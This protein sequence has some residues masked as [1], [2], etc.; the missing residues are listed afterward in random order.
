MGDL[1][2]VIV[3]VGIISRL[4]GGNGGGLLGDRKMWMRLLGGGRK[5]G[6]VGN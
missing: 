2:V 1:A 6:G 4:R 3:V 5:Q